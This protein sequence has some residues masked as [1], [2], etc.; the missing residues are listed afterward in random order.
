MK[1]ADFGDAK[2]LQKLGTGKKSVEK[3]PQKKQHAPGRGRVVKSI[4]GR[5]KEENQ[6]V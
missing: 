3:K 5:E 4:R 2:H 6:R 1:G